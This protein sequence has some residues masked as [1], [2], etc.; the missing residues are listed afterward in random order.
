MMEDNLYASHIIALA[1]KLIVNN[2][3]YVKVN[4]ISN[5]A[6]LYIKN[7]EDYNDLNDDDK[8]NIMI[9]LQQHYKQALN[10]S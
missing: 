1:N 10:K 2:Y 6:V 9:Y 4:T 3:V 5:K 7:N 8:Y